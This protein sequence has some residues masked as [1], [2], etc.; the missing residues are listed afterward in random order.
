MEEKIVSEE[1]IVDMADFFS[2]RLLRPLRKLV[3]SDSRRLRNSLTVFPPSL[4]KA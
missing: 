4:R 3:V 1:E 2:C